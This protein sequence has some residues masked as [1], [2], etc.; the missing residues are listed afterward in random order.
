MRAIS[1]TE[2]RQKLKNVMDSVFKDH[3]PVVVTRKKG[4]N[5]IIMSQEDY[6]SLME[7]HYLL[8]SPANAKHLLKSVDESNRGKKI[9]QDKIKL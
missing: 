4:E 7:T 9:P 5:V 8:S 1:Y 2:A 6:D 3:K